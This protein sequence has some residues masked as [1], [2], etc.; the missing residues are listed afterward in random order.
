MESS[1]STMQE[2]LKQN[3]ARSLAPAQ[4]Q[5]WVDA[6]SPIT[7]T[8]D[9]SMVRMHSKLEEVAAQILETMGIQVKNLGEKQL[10]EVRAQFT[11]MMDALSDI[12]KLT[13]LQQPLSDM[14]ESVKAQVKGS[15]SLDPEKIDDQF[16]T[17][18]AKVNGIGA[19]VNGLVKKAEE[20]L[21]ARDRL[22]P[23]ALKAGIDET[24]TKMT[25]A[26]EALIDDKLLKSIK[27]LQ[28]AT[29]SRF[30]EQGITI[31]ELTSIGK[32]NTGLLR[33]VR[34][35]LGE[36][37]NN[38][39][40][41]KATQAVVESMAEQ[42]VEMGEQLSKLRDMVEAQTELLQGKREILQ[43]LSPPYRPPP[44]GGKGWGPTSQAVP[45]SLEEAIRNPG[46]PPIYY[47]AN[48]AAPA[49]PQSAAMQHMSDLLMQ[50]TE[51]LHSMRYN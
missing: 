16:K 46:Q 28:G 32:S 11:Q 31:A 51:M 47:A 19:L 44:M 27:L 20:T 48:T 15:W 38:L 39:A 22:G 3:L 12:A 2:I 29:Q 45:V 36:H 33:E 6:M 4:V 35:A 40:V 43:R 7:G 30:Q 49:R 8:V 13:Q 21:Q 34:N 42:Q 9:D 10:A 26:W 41:V 24:A 14:L 25:A 37:R 1:D 5:A 17:V 18:V 50:I 23:G